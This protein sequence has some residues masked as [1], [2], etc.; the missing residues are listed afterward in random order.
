LGAKQDTA[1]YNG[2]HPVWHGRGVVV[3]SRLNEAGGN[4]SIY[5]EALALE[6]VQAPYEERMGR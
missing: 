3:G 5:D 6:N 2:E 1:A 4:V